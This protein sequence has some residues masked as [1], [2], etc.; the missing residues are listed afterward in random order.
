MQHLEFSPV[1]IIGAPRSGTN[2]LR[3]TLCRIP[4]FRTW[5]CDEINPIWRHGN[6]GAATDALTPEMV[7]A[8]VRRFIRRAFTRQWRRSGR[9]AFLVEK[10]C[11]NALRVSFVQAVLPEAKFVHIVRDGLDV[12]PSAARRWRGELEM[13]GLP[14]FLAKARNTPVTDLPAY[15]WHFAAGRLGRVLGRSG[16]LP[17]WGPRFEGLMELARTAPLEEVCARQWAACVDASDAAF[18]TMPDSQWTQLTYEDFV[19][20]PA[21]ALQR[22]LHFLG[23]TADEAEIASAVKGV[24][25]R[26]LGKGRG[27]FEQMSRP[28]LAMMRPTLE[29][30]GYLKAREAA[31]T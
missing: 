1:I 23:A 19:R 22:V 16:Q 6:S 24:S 15:A 30:H 4:T 2:I 21:G 7:R 31:E 25:P 8:P 13:A 20:Y 12:V 9:P 18:A 5:D 29:R 14:Y 28:T 27:S 3:D 26:S 17:I 11:A 10:T